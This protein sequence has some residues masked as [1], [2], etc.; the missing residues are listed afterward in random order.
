[1]DDED[2]GEAE[3]TDEG[4][5]QDLDA[6]D[7]DGYD[8]TEDHESNLDG[9]TPFSDD[10]SD[11]SANSADSLQEPESQPVLSPQQTTDAEQ[12]RGDIKVIEY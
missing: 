11:D 5:Q 7:D 12:N 1:M 10:M 8:D 9:E 4:E 2:G 6:G 3:Q